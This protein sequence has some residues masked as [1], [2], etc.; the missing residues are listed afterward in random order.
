MRI[1]GRGANQPHVDGDG[2]VPQPFFAPDF[3]PLD[4]RFGRPRVQPSAVVARVD[5]GSDPH[6]CNASGPARGNVSKEL[7]YH[8]LWKIVGFDPIVDSQTAELRGESPMPAHDAP[9]QAFVGQVVKPSLAA[10]ALPGGIDQRQI[11]WSAVGEKSPF[12]G[13]GQGLWVATTDEPAA[14]DRST[15]L[16]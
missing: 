9:Q 14:G 5:E 11:A 2:L 1:G 16:N 3:Q 7:T 10:V 8:A 13:M 6:V 12:Q 15:V 4:Q